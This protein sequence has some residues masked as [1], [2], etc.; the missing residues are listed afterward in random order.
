ME[1]AQ[2]SLEIANMLCMTQDQLLEVVNQCLAGMLQ[3]FLHSV[4]DGH[5]SLVLR[6]T[7]SGFV[8]IEK[9]IRHE[10]FLQKK[11][12]FDDTKN[13]YLQKINRLK[14]PKE[15]KIYKLGRI[16]SP[17]QMVARISWAPTDARKHAHRLGG[18]L[19][20]DWMAAT[21]HVAA[22]RVGRVLHIRQVMRRDP[23]LKLNSLCHLCWFRVSGQALGTTHC[24]L[25]KTSVR[26]SPS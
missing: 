14:L 21:L 17:K 6:A 2:S 25:C 13:T 3:Q 11:K 24:C 15:K 18:T 5:A 8:Q 12:S 10:N 4:P 1:G 9:R 20:L 16:T 7:E 22:F 19:H 26:R 23:V